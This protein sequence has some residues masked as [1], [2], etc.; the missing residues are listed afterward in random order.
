MRLL[1]LVATTL[2][3]ALG[4]AAIAQVPPAKVIETRQANYKQMGK[5]FKAIRDQYSSG[6][7]DIA[8]IQKNAAII[9]SLAPQITSWFPAGTGASAGK[10]EALPA[11]WEKPADFKAAANRLVTESAKLKTLADAGDLAATGAQVKAVGASCGGCHDSFK[12]KDD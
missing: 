9:A 8:V 12:K 3:L 7:P 5:A 4:S 10:T 2:M 6:S 1:P 11:I